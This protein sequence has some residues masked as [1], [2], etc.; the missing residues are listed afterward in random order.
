MD[1]EIFALELNH[2]WDVIPL[3]SGKTPIGCKWVYRIKYN[4]D[5][6]IERYK[7]IFVA[8][9]YTQQEGLD[10][11]ET[12]S[13]VAKCVSIRV[14]LCIAA[15]KG[16]GLHQLDVN[17]AFLHGGSHEEVYM[18]LPQGFHSKG[19]CLASSNGRPLVCRLR[20]SI[21][22][23]KQLVDSGMLSYLP[24]SQDLVLSSPNQIMHFLFIPKALVL[25][26]C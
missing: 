26:P 5:G 13:P 23:L 4:L 14:F 21:Y 22:D 18:T 12:F 8:K 11:L 15:V 2:T 3:P 1:K 17:N 20:K 25:Q 24:P 16:R 9:G 6:S 19:D 10:Y 7:A